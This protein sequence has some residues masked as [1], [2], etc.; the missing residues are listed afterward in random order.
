[1]HVGIICSYKRWGTCYA[2]SCSLQ[3]LPH[4]PTIVENFLAIVAL[5]TRLL[6]LHVTF[7]VDENYLVG[8]AWHA[9]PKSRAIDLSAKTKYKVLS[10]EISS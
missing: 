2:D 1:M 8:F 6:C 5:R 7:F 10:R 4:K 3:K 9:A